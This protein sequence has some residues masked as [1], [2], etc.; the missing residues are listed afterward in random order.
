[1]SAPHPDSPLPEVVME[2]GAAL[3]AQEAAVD[4]NVQFRCRAPDCPQE[5]S[6]KGVGTLDQLSFRGCAS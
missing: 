2:S 4:G 6:E 3:D 5:R 1:M